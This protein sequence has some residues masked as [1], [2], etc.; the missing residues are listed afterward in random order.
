MRLMI[1]VSHTREGSMRLMLSPTIPGR[2]LCASCLPYTSGWCIPGLYVSLIPQG[3]VYLA[4]C[5]PVYPRVWYT[6]VYASLYT[7]G[8]VYTSL[9]L[10]DTPKCRE[11]SQAL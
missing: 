11:A 9:C 6:R 5:L 2:A 10:P 1:N 4:I 8:G 7:L 3:G